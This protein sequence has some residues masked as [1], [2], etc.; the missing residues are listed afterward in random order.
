M[1]V[2]KKKL[3]RRTVLRGMGVTLALPLLDA[4][5]PA[6]TPVA[7]TAAAP[8]RRLG[9]VYLASG[10]WMSRWR[11][12]E[13]VLSEL[14]PTLAPLAPFK[15]QLVVPMGLDHRQAEAFGDGNG[16]HSRAGAV[17]LSG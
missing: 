12:Q 6:L 16:D 8:V 15:D 9:F 3:A 7:H 4:M 1:I 2:T 14:S 5:V 10:C 13:G 11:P 17:Y